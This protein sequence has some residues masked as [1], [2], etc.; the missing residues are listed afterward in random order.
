MNRSLTAEEFKNSPLQFIEAL[1]ANNRQGH[2]VG[3]VPFPVKV[4]QFFADID[5]QIFRVLLQRLDVTRPE[6]VEVVLR[7][8]TWFILHESDG[9]FFSCSE[10]TAITSRS[11]ALSVK[12]GWR[13]N[14]AN[15]HQ[16]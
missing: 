15:L 13:K 16:E 9:I 5:S 11:V 6:L 8:L 2:D 7:V 14:W 4:E 3:R 10:L 12:R 1:V